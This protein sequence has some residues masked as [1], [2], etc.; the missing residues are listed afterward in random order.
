MNRPAPIVKI[1]AAAREFAEALA[2]LA[3]DSERTPGVTDS[4][5]SAHLPPRTSRRR[6]AEICRSGQV[7]G[8]TLEGRV[9]VCSR[10]A[11]HAARGRRK[12]AAAPSNPSL[13]PEESV[14]ALL[15]RR[16]FRLID[17]AGILPASQRSE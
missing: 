12:E 1:A 17:K 4:Y 15:S 10:E 16:G 8:A 14:D 11:W 7:D 13:T 2:E 5:D 9:W 6:F 3:R